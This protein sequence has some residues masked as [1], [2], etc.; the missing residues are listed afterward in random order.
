MR[1]LHTA[2]TSSRIER[3]ICSRNVPTPPD[4]INSICGV[5]G[6]TGNELGIGQ[7]CETLDD[8]TDT[9]AAFLCSNIGDET[10]LALIVEDPD[11]PTPRPMVHAILLDIDKLLDD[12]SEVLADTLGGNAE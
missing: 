1:A 10:S 8:C 3:A 2:V 7:F 11:A 9:E 5:P 12:E 6:D 4:A